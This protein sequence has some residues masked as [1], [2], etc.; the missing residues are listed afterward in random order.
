MNNFSQHH[1]YN[2]AWKQK[3]PP[4]YSLLRN[5]NVWKSY[6]HKKLYILIEKTLIIGLE[7]MPHVQK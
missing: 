2:S 1:N 4:E 5:S 3:V 7:S 6:V